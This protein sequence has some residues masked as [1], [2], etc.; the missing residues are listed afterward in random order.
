MKVDIT[1]PLTRRSFEL[2]EDL[3]PKDKVLSRLDLFGHIGTHLDLMEKEYPEANFSLSGRIFDVSSIR[4]RDIEAAD[5]DIDQV[6]EGDFVIMHTGGLAAY[7]YGTKEYI[8]APIQLSW[9]LLEA[10][11]ARKAALI[12]VDLAGVRLPAEHPKADNMCAEAGTFIIENLYH[13]KTLNTEAKGKSF[14]V[15]TYPMR[16]EGSTGLPCRVVANI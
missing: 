10:L 11:V 12:G 13:L 9:N 16:L 14:V 2:M 15:N 8:F 7:G 3:A 4:G 1:F 5:I 6:R